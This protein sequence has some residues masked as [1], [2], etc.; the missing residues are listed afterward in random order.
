MDLDYEA[1]SK[2]EAL[3][4]LGSLNGDGY[5]L[6]QKAEQLLLPFS[7]HATDGFLAEHDSE[8]FPTLSWREA[9]ADEQRLARDA[10][11]MLDV[12]AYQPVITGEEIAGVLCDALGIGRSSGKAI[13]QARS[14]REGHGVM[15]HDIRHE[16]GVEPAED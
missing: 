11:G 1:I 15:I 8:Q 3:D 9:I 6:P 4:Q 16:L 13:G 2:D 14:A 10:R 7:D 12:P 5:Y